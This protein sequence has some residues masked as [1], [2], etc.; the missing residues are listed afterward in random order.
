LEELD[1]GLEEVPEGAAVGFG[2]VRGEAGGAVGF[3]GVGEV[4]A[5]VE[6]GV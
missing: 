5:E 2:E 6:A 1:L 3:E 4:F